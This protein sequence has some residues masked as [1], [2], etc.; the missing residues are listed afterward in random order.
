MASIVLETV[1]EADAAEVWAVIGDFEQGPPR[2]APGFVTGTELTA[3]D[4]RT[5]TFANG[6]VIDERLVSLDHEAQRIVWAVIGGT[7]RPLHDN[8]SLQVVAE[9]ERLSRLVWIRDVLPDELAPPLA[10]TMADGLAVIR[11]T[12]SAGQA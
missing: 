9:S 8:A 11:E 3:D 4:V 12:L 2:M 10:A 5:V 7:V 1:I 6:D